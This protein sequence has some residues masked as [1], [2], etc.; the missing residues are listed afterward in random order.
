[1]EAPTKVITSLEGDF[2][3][4]WSPDGKR[5]AFT[6]LRNQIPAIYVIN[7]NDLSFQKL[8]PTSK[9]DK[10][11]SW[12]PSGTQIAFVRQFLS[13]QIW[14]MM[15]NGQFQS[16][17]SP[18]GPLN[19]LWPSWSIDG[20]VIFYSQSN[21]EK[22]NPWLVYRRYEDREKP[23]ETRIPATARGDSGPFA[24]VRPSPDG[25]QL[26]YESWPDGNN[27]DIYIMNANGS[28]P[29]RLTTDPGDDFGPAWRPAAPLQQP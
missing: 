8:S 1:E 27:H 4:A 26:V 17:F 24:Q 23:I 25:T 11:P 13:S 29:Q 20:Q 7:L 3:P 2:D 5:I 21:Q 9:P 22:F 19:N 28:N 15:D 18:L 14:I 10:Q 12:S 6:S 16:Q